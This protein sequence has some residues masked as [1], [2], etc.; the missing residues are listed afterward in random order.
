MD[1]D[2]LHE[3]LL[4][5]RRERRG[6]SEADKREK[7]REEDNKQYLDSARINRYVDEAAMDVENTEEGSPEEERAVKSLK[8]FQKMRDRFN[9][10]KR[11]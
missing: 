9:N 3:K 2:K 1:Y 6:D 8:Y 11:V 7:A 10:K 5:R 4:K